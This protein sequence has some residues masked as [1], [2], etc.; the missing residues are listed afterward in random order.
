[1]GLKKHECIF[2][3]FRKKMGCFSSY[4][5]ALCMAISICKILLKLRLINKRNMTKKIYLLNC[6]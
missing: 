3:A 5:F 2:W 4:L 1:M 6:R